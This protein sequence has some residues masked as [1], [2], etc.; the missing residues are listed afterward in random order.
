[1]F[2]LIKQLRRSGLQAAHNPRRAQ[3]TGDAADVGHGR[4]GK[5]QVAVRQLLQKGR[6]GRAD[7]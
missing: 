4:P 3:P 7:V 2:S 6:R 5:V 1:M